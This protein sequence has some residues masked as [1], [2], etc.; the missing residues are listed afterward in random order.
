VA[1]GGRDLECAA[2]PRLAADLREI[3]RGGRGIGR[4]PGAAQELEPAGS[5]EV[6]RHLREMGGASDPRALD[7]PRLGRVRAGHD[8][9][10]PGPGRLQR[11]GQRTAQRPELAAQ[12]QFAKE[13]RTTERIGRDLPRRD[14]EAERDRQV[15]TSAFLRKIRGREIDR[16]APRWEF[17]S[18]RRQ[19]R[20]HSV[21]ALAHD[22][23]RQA[24]DQ[25]RR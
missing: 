10:V 15:E 3:R 23:L 1:T 20:A 12:R 16:D 24:D 5:G 25:Y 17:E 18:R 14:Q 22:G 13:L 6:A 7:Q 19:R 8:H 2:R 9:G 21:T 4:A 11:R